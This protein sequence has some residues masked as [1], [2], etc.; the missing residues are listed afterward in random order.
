VRRHKVGEVAA[1]ARG[2]PRLKLRVVDESPSWVLIDK[3]AGFHTHPPEDKTMRIS[4]RWNALAILERQLNR[5]LFPMHR[6]DRAT[7]GLLLYSKNRSLNGALQAQ[8]AS[9]QISKT[10]FSLLRGKFIGEANLDSALKSENGSMQQAETKVSAYISFTLPILHPNGGD[11]YFTIVRAEPLT[12]RF[13]Q[14]RRHLAQLGFPIIGDTRH[15]DRKLN[16][17][18]AALTGCARLF[19]RAMTLEFICPDTGKNR[20]LHAQWSRDWH[21]IFELAGACPLTSSPFRERPSLS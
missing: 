18:F 12:G 16:R 10:Y 9:R 17:E 14:I 5:E 8:F 2:A 1:P 21:R 19:L 7:S 13:H 6:L 4:P 3:P 11:R 20:S 15:G